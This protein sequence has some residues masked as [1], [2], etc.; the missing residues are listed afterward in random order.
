MLYG[1]D[2]TAVSKTDEGNVLIPV[3]VGFRIEDLDLIPCDFFGIRSGIAWEPGQHSENGRA[4]KRW[5]IAVLR[6]MGDHIE[7]ADERPDRAARRRLERAGFPADGYVSVLRLRKAIYGDSDG[8]GGGPP[9][10]FRH[11]VRGHW[12]RF[13]APSTGLPVGDPEA[14]RHRFV[15]DYL[16]GPKDSVRRESKQVIV[17]GR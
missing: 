9:L 14:Y 11:R 6:L 2:F 1:R 15:N 10:R 4:M 3:D 8:L 16:R 17:V 5:L 13:Y 7:R 12:R